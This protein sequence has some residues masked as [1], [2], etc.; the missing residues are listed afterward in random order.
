[1]RSFD[2]LLDTLRPTDRPGTF[3]IEIGPQW[4]QGRTIFGGLSAALGVRAIKN[5]LQSQGD[6]RPLAS[7]DVGFVGP[8][9]P[10][11]I[12]VRAEVLRAGRSV[13]QA[14]ADV[15][16]GGEIATRIHAVF[17]APRPTEEI[18]FRETSRRRIG[19]IFRLTVSGNF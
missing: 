10:G 6:S 5:I 13:I 9:P 11:E 8:A 4:T 7:I 12:V 17:A 15:C 14:S 1:M 3:A 18:L 19:P 16:S 2:Q